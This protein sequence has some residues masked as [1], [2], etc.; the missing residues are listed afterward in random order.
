MDKLVEWINK[1]AELYPLDKEAEQPRTW[2]P[3]CRQELYAYFRVLIHI[4]ITI[5]PAIKDYWKDLNTQQ[6]HIP[7]YGH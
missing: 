2:Q 4:R 7:G 5:G 3:T 6:P 1:H